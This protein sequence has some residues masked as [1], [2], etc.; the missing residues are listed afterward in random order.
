M[1]PQLGRGHQ[2]LQCAIGRTLRHAD[3][4]TKFSG[5][6][7]RFE[8][9]GPIGGL[10]GRFGNHDGLM[11]THHR[12]A[13]VGCIPGVTAADRSS[14]SRLVHHYQ[15]LRHQLIIQNRLLDD[16]GKRIRAASG[17]K[18]HDHSYRFLWIHIAPAR[19][20]QEIV[21]NHQRRKSDNRGMN[22]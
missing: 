3:D 14:S 2:S 17:L 19:T 4:D 18:G 12:V 13:V 22:E 20:H 10:T 6:R 7:H 16:P 5:G 21:K 9:V 11:Q 8:I 1:G 15:R